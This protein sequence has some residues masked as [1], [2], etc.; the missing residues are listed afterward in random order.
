[1]STSFLES[2]KLMN[3]KIKRQTMWGR[4]YF[5]KMVAL[6]FPIS[7]LFLQYN[8]NKFLPKQMGSIFPTLEPEWTF[9]S[10][11]VHSRNRR[12]DTT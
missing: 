9:V 10:A 7:Y 1:M 3:K 6:T 11:S 12:N 5:P 8:V 2:E 4:L